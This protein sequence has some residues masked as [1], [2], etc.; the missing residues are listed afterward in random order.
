MPWAL[1][2]AVEDTSQSIHIYSGDQKLSVFW[3]GTRLLEAGLFTW[4]FITS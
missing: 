4:S 2:T 1:A 3:G